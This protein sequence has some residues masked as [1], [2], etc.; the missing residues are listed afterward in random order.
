MNELRREDAMEQSFVRMAVLRL[1]GELHRNTPS[2]KAY[3]MLPLNLQ[4]RSKLRISIQQKLQPFC[5]RFVRHGADPLSGSESHDAKYI[6]ASDSRSN[7][8][9]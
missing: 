8:S 4:L 1:V 9:Y 3:D 7:F 5:G 6:P 2:F